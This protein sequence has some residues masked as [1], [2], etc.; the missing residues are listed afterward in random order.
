MKMLTEKNFK[1]FLLIALSG[2]IPSLMSGCGAVDSGAYS[3]TKYSI[4]NAMFSQTSA[5]AGYNCPSSPQVLPNQDINFDGSQRYVACRNTGTATQILLKG[6]SSSSAMVCVYPIQYINTNQFVYKASPSGLPM[7][8][9]GDMQNT[10][11]L[12]ASFPAT[13]F[14]AVIVVDYTDQLNMSRCLANG[15]TCP[16]Y[17][18]GKLQ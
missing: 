2:A 4:D 5:D 17:S 10:Y 6:Y 9:C 1:S 7:F 16:N 8:Q 13:N 15:Q 18:I 3:K 14:N 12:E 11:R